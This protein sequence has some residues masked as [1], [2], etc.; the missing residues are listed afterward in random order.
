KNHPSSSE[1][2]AAFLCH[3]A[4]AARFGHLCVEIDG[5]IVT[6]SVEA[7]WQNGENSSPTPDEGQ[8]ALKT[9]NELVLAGVATLP[10]E[11]VTET[12]MEELDS[13]AVQTPLC[14]IQNKF[15]LQRHWYYETYFLCHYNKF[16]SQPPELNVDDNL[17]N[18]M[19]TT[20]L[21]NGKL[22]P[23]QAEAIQ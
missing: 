22:L 12:H 4:A 20:L 14:K 11:L 17:V 1:C 18:S 13:R 16:I 23:A 5:P 6:P 19:T 8:K 7:V 9:I 21:N 10:V 2:T 15:Y 3:L